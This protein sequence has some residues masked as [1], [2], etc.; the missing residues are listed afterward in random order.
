M[1]TL[2]CIFDGGLCVAVVGVVGLVTSA[3]LKVMCPEFYEK[4]CSGF[5]S[6]KRCDNH[7]H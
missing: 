5:F 7:N 1:F 3:I 6:K 4:H 2:A